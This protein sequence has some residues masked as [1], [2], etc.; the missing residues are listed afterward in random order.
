MLE[1]LPKGRSTMEQGEQYGGVWIRLL[2]LV[3]DIAILIVATLVI[4]IGSSFLGPIGLKIGGLVVTLLPVLYWPVMQASARQATYGK[5]MLG[6]K[7]ADANGARISWLRSF[8]RELAKLFSMIPL[9][10]GF[11]IAAFT[12]RRQALHDLLAS[13]LVLREGPAHVA[14]AITVA[15]VGIVGPMIAIPMFFMAIFM[16]MIA[17]IFGE[18]T[19]LLKKMPVQVTIQA[20]VAQAPAA[21]PATAAPAA[22]APP[23][24]GEDFDRLMGAPL[25]G[26]EKPGATRAGPALL[27]LSTMFSSSVWIKVYLPLPGGHGSGRWSTRARGD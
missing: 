4:M 16:A 3:V 17:S 18:F 9:L 13:T 20:P 6:L 1:D 23:G 19:G 26:L 2:A 27:E 15:V 8:W 12:A 22:Q 14:G 7:V 24:S 5:A 25:T 10:I 21:A 11:L